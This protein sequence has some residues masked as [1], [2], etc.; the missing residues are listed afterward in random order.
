[1]MLTKLLRLS[2]LRPSG[3][4]VRLCLSVEHGHGNTRILM[5]RVEDW[6]REA[7]EDLESAK[8]LLEGGQH[9]HVCFHAQQAVERALKAL[10]RSLHKARTGHSVL[11]LLREASREVEIPDEL[12][13]YARILDQYYIPPRYPNAFSEGPPANIILE[14]RPRRRSDMLRRW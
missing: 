3:S 7:E 5:G 4:S 1:M 8:I 9:H 14:D 6:L 2:P 12:W 10:L 11:D 13:D